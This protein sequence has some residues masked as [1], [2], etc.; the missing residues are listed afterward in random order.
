[1]YEYN[2][3]EIMLLVVTVLPIDKP[4][5]MRVQKPQ[6]QAW[7]PFELVVNKILETPKNK[8]G[9]SVTH[10]CLTLLQFKNTSVMTPHTSD[11]T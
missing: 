11:R 5:A 10:G 3:S 6:Y 2:S 7:K 4:W 1:M 8:I 9:Y